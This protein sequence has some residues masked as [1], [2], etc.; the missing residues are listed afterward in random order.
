MS[1]E[2]DDLRA[3]EKHPGYLRLLARAKGFEDSIIAQVHNATSADD[4]LVILNLR[5]LV[6]SHRAVETLLAWPRERISQLEQMQD[7][8]A[9]AAEP[10][11]S[12]GGF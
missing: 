6:A 11:Y 4:S 9:V 12:R 2:L 1:D 5:L 3:L 10:S 7:K 8:A